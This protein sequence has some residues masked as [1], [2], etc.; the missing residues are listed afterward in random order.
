MKLTPPVPLTP[1]QCDWLFNNRGYRCGAAATVG[2]TNSAAS[3]W[4]SVAAVFAGSANTGA[5][6]VNAALIGTDTNTRSLTAGPAALHA[7]PDAT[8]VAA[9]GQS[10]HVLIFPAALTLA[11]IKAV[12]N[13]LGYQYGLPTVP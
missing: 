10:A 9:S 12:H 4:R 2:Y 5:L 6:Y 7:A 13:L 8:L 1:G 11:Q 3:T